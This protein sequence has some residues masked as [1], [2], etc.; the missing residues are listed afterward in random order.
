MGLPVRRF[1]K[2]DLYEEVQTVGL[3][4]ILW[5]QISYYKPNGA[6]FFANRLGVEPADLKDVGNSQYV[7]VQKG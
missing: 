6:A 4:P 7:V 1:S 5:R 2:N 3:H